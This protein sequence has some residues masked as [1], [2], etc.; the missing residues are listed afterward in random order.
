[1]LGK[2]IVNQEP[3]L[4]RS[5]ATSKMAIPSMAIPKIAST[6]CIPAYQREWSS[7]FSVSLRKFFFGS[8]SI[9]GA[10]KTYYR[11]SADSPG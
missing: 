1:M 5:L 6:N 9:L 11:L 3:L 7:S 10:V 2:Q 4:F 8:D